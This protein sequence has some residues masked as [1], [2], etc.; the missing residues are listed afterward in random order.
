MA[1]IEDLAENYGVND[2]GIDTEDGCSRLVQ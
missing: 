2:D 1:N